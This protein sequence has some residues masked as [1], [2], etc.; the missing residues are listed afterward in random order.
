ML[1][2]S[3]TNFELQ[4]LLLKSTHALTGRRERIQYQE[5]T[6]SWNGNYYNLIKKKEL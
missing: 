4:S 5:V 2:S 3:I 1:I 6:L